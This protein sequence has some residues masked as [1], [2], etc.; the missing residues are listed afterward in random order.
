MQRILYVLTGSRLRSVSC[1][2]YQSSSPIGASVKKVSDFRLPDIRMAGV[3][4]DLVTADKALLLRLYMRQ[5]LH[6][7]E[8]RLSGADAGDLLRDIVQTG[9]CFWESFNRRP[10]KWAPEREARLTWT[11]AEDSLIRPELR[12]D[13]PSGAV[14]PAPV[15]FFL[16]AVSGVCGRLRTN[17][18]DGLVLAWMSAPVMDPSTAGIFYAN[19]MERYPGFDFPPPITSNVE[20]VRGVHPTPCLHLGEMTYYDQRGFGRTTLPT[21]HLRFDYEGVE[22]SW[23]AP[24]EAVSAV[25][26]DRLRKVFRDTGR[27]KEAR[28]HFKALG[29]RPIAEA[30]PHRTLV[31]SEG[32]HTFD[33]TWSEDGVADFAQALQRMQ[34]AGWRV[35]TTDNREL[36]PVS[37]ETWYSELTGSTWDWFEFEVGIRIDGQTVNLL[38]VLHGLL[39]K[40]GDR[41]LEQIKKEL[42]NHPVFVPLNAKQ[43]C[44]LPPARLIGIVDKLFELFDTE[45]L[46]ASNRL[47]LDPLR[48]A[49]VIELEDLAPEPWDASD[50][51]RRL[52]DLLKHGL[53]LKPAA[54]PRGLRTKLRPYQAQGL[55]WLQ[56]LREYEMDGILADDMGLGKT[57]QTL[58]HLLVEKK[59]GRLAKPSIVIAPTSLM[60]NWMDEATRFAPQLKV[61]LLHGSERHGRFKRIVR[62]DLLLTT[63]ALMRFDRDLYRDLNF[64]YVIL[65][66]AQAVK[67]P[68]SQSARIICQL[69]SDRRLCLTGTPLENHLG[70]LWSLFHFLMPGFLGDERGF[71]ARFRDPIEKHGLVD[72]QTFL[73]RRIAPFLLRRTKDEVEADLPPKTEV[74]HTVELTDKQRDLYETVRV[75]M[76]ARVRTEIARK[77]LKRSHI[78]V[79]DALLKLRQICCDPRLLKQS[80]IK[81]TGRDSAKLTFLMRLLPELIEEG[82]RVLLFSQFTSMLTLIEERLRRTGIRHVKLTG[83]TRD[84]ATPIEQFQGGEVPLFLISLKAGGT[85][86]NLTAADA[87]IHYDPWWNP[88]VERQATDRAHRIGQD[89]PVFVYKLLTEGT[90]EAKIQKMQE[91]KRRLAEGILSGSIKDKLAFTEEDLT[92]LF[93]PVGQQG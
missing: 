51:V 72:R 69:K 50:Q 9:R 17:F 73:S 40:Y 6:A 82:R 86:L 19:L 46:N 49:E 48:V 65:D 64:S 7:S 61:T 43:S 23:D 45:P 90:V 36:Q 4:E 63:Y 26:D 88:A 33:A 79:L 70:E 84:R 32:L 24:R 58:A 27:E 57:V 54:P 2:L 11:V 30:H 71:K 56:F 85:G 74:I 44:L 22:V 13:P 62:S 76:D 83:S 52:V 15:P 29:F 14:F 8:I 20:E 81:A 77:G 59:A 91:T 53:T 16:D 34:E 21:A 3:Q 92:V 66:E 28:H 60:K 39:R 38:P 25:R 80:K 55:A 41:S 87:V 93:E 18:P 12:M 5:A 31:E 75:A 42:G 47:E 78:I 37:Q 1:R 10:L 89:K 67:N 68:K 35:T